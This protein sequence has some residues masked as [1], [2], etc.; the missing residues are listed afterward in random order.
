MSQ[1]RILVLAPDA[2]PESISVSLV[3]YR[4]AEALAQFHSGTLVGRSINE[5]ALRRTQAPF[6]AIVAISMPWLD[7]IFAWSLRWIFGNNFHS[8]AL[9]AF[10]YPFSIAFEWRAFWLSGSR[11]M[12]GQVDT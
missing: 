7:R 1:L 6:H 2:N 4:H 8:R 11:R 12:S 5:A 3:C 10:W 9:A